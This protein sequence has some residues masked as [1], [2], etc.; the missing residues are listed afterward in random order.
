LFAAGN[1]GESVKDLKAAGSGEADVFV[2]AFGRA[3]K[4]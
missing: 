4:T 1:F 2:C 3:G